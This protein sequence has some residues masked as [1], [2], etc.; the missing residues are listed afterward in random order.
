MTD[1]DKI[2]AI[3]NAIQT[4]SQLILLLQTMIANN[5]VNVPSANLTVMC[6]I[7]GISTL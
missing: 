2:T 7:L 1:Q 5:I 6:Q 4:E 3:L